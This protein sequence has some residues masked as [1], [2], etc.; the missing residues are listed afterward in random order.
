MRI[1]VVDNQKRPLMPCT[2]AKARIL[3]KRG[4]LGIFYVQLNDQPEPANQTLVIGIDPGSKFELRFVPPKL[5][6][7]SGQGMGG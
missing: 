4:K 7:S 3:L 5:T 6:A 1:P 2:P